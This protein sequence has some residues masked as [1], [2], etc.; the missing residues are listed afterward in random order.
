MNANRF[1]LCMIVKNESG[2]ILR[3]L[4]AIEPHIIGAAITDTGSTDNTVAIITD[5]FAKHNKACFINH[6]E[7]IDFSQARNSA[8][9]FAR[10]LKDIDWEFL[11]LQDADMELQCKGPIQKLEPRCYAIMQKNDQVQ[12][13]NVRILNRAETG[14]YKGRTHECIVPV[15]QP[16]AIGGIWFLDHE[17]GA[18]RTNKYKRDIELLKLDLLDDPLNARSVFYMIQSLAGIGMKEKAREFCDM[19]VQ[20]NDKGL[21]EENFWN[22]YQMA[23]FDEDLGRDPA[24]I[25]REYLQAYEYRPTRAEPL[26]RLAMYL[27]QREEHWAAHIFAREAATIP[28][29]AEILPAQVEIY[30][31]IALD[32]WLGLSIITNNIPEARKAAKRLRKARLPESERVRILAN[33]DLV[34]KGPNK[35][36]QINISP[37]ELGTPNETAPDHEAVPTASQT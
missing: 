15:T 24:I 35:L 11:F 25:Q 12:Y 3:A 16:M 27:R 33:C 32:E 19:R 34:L 8:L 4:K 10:G 28:L 17:T 29:P 23:Q 22:L 31:W 21:E 18:N 37:D 2:N 30:E 26:L 14:E 5:F 9:R 1:L 36:K 13:W 7:F 6:D 20:L